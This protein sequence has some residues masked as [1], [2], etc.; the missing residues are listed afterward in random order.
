MKYLYLIMIA[1]VGFVEQGFSQAELAPWGNVT[2]V[3]KQGQLLDFETSLQYIKSD[4]IQILTTERERQRP[5]YSRNGNRQTV[6]TNLDSLYFEET[7]TESGG[8]KAELSIKLNAHSDTTLIGAYFI[9][10]IPKKYHNEAQFGLTDA[11]QPLNINNLT[12]APVKERSASWAKGF[13]FKSANFKIKVSGKEQDSILVRK[14]ENNGD[15]LVYFTIRTKA[16][17]RG[18][19][20]QKTYKLEADGEVDKSAV[21]VTLNSSRQGRAFEGLG[22]NFRLQ[23]PTDPQ[24][25]DYSLANLR[26]AWGRV[27]LPW[28]LWQPEKDG[29]PLDAARENRL[30][31]KIIQSMEMA[32]RLS[33]MG[34]P[35]ILSAWSAPDWAIVGTQNLNPVNGVWG[36]PLNN[37]V[38]TDIYRSLSRYI[39]Y[40]KDNYGVEVKMFSFN[41]SDLGINIRMTA[42]EHADFIKGFGSYMNTKGLKTKLLLGDNSDAT[43][44]AFIT[45]AMNDAAARPYIGAIS[46]HSWRG[47]DTETL[48]KWADAA[49]QLNVPLLVGEGSIDA[50]AWQYP[51][52]FQEPTYAI[53]EINLYTRML[54]ICQPASILQWQL[55]ADYSP[56]AGGGIFGDNGPLRPTQ[57]FWNLKQL[58]LTPPNLYA[59]LVSSNKTEISCAALG[60]NSKGIYTIHLV[61]N[62]ADRQM[63]LKGL[64]A[65][66]QK[67]K[68][69]VTNTEN[70]AKESGSKKASNGQLQFKLP[71][72]SY[73]TLISE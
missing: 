25:I 55:T 4:G 71:V 12:T 36:N 17:K 72:R 58:S 53:E 13:E 59:M 28:R 69:Y 54:A 61:N 66:A 35:V 5:V 20:I 37:D 14:D 42:Q 32:Q 70:N 64:P 16:I 39:T 31:A 47:W 18:E 51:V 46:F 2:G 50:A 40:L 67:F 26:L 27:E 43:T 52:I 7:L 38:I 23:N 19:V 44:S 1:M 34:I 22:G 45:T 21:V 6:N 60:D 33:K 11:D 10:R 57:R 73:I 65:K 56:L 62:G 8:E 24:V 9:V 49:T 41:E 68:V 3:R 63:T 29:N 15:L 30:P 48:K